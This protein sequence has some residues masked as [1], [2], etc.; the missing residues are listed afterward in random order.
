MSIVQ[1]SQPCKYTQKLINILFLKTFHFQKIFKIFI[2]I[3]S[4][5]YFL[6]YFICLSYKLLL[7]PVTF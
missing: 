5:N 6:S 2:E 1:V 3:S 7:I 4:E